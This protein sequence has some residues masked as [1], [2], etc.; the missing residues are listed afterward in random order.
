ME[1]SKK[2]KFGENINICK[3][4]LFRIVFVFI[5]FTHFF[6]LMIIVFSYLVR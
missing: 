5:Q 4:T 6:L 2:E 1:K 3:N